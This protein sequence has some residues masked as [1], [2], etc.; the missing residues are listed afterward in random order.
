MKRSQPNPTV[1]R[2]RLMRLEPRMLYDGAAMAEAVAVDASHHGDDGP[3]HGHGHTHESSAGEKHH[4]HY[5]RSHGTDET[6]ARSDRESRHVADAR[7]S[8]DS[9]IQYFDFDVDVGSLTPELQEAARLAS[10]SILDFARQATDEQWF[11]LFNGGNEMPDAA[12]TARLNDLRTAL[13]DGSLSLHVETIDFAVMPDAIAAYTMNGPDGGLTIFINPVWTGMMEAPDLTHILVH[14]IGHAFDDILNNGGDTP[15][16]EGELFSDSILGWAEDADTLQRLQAKNDHR[17]IEWN[18]VSYEVDTATFSFVSTYEM[19]YGTVN[20]TLSLAV[21]ENSSIW[22]DTTDLGASFINDSDSGQHFNGNDVSAIGLNIG[23]ADYYGWISRPIKSE[24]VIRG[25]YFW[26]DA[27]FVDLASAQADGNKDG[28]N[29]PNDNRGF[30]LVIDQAWFAQQTTI[31]V[32]I[33]GKT[34]TVAN[35]KSSSDRVDTA[36]NA[37]VDK[38]PQPPAVTAEAQSAMAVEAGYEVPGSN[39]S[40]NV[41]DHAQSATGEDLTVTRISVANSSSSVQDVA[42]DGAGTTIA[43]KYGTLTIHVDGSYEYVVDNA[44]PKVDALNVGGTLDDVFTY[45]VSDGKG[46]IASAT[47]TIVIAGSNDAPQANPDY[48]SAKVSVTGSDVGYSATGN[49][50]LNDTDVDDSTFI[51]NGLTLTADVTVGLVNVD[52]GST[53]LSFPLGSSPNSVAGYNLYYQDPNAANTYYPLVYWDDASSKY[54]SITSAVVGSGSTSTLTLSGTPT[55]YLVGGSTFV[56][57]SVTGGDTVGFQNKPKDPLATL[58]NS[59]GTTALQVAAATASGSTTLYDFNGLEGAIAVGMTVKVDGVN[60]GAKVTAVNYNAITGELESVALD[61]PLTGITFDG[62]NQFSFEAPSSDGHTIQGAYGTLT[63]NGYGDYTYTPYA[64]SSLKS[65]QSAEEVFHYTI[66]DSGGLQSSS[67]LT[68]TVYGS[69]TD[70]LAGASV[71]A[72]ESGYNEPGWDAT[73]TVLSGSKWTEVVSFSRD[74]GTTQDAGQALQGAYG[75]LTIRAD[76]TFDYVVDNGNKTVNALQVGGTLTETFIYKVTDAG[77][78]TSY[79]RLTITIEGT[80]DA[81]VAENDAAAV[82]KGGVETATGNVLDNDTDVDT[83]DILRVSRA[84]PS[85]DALEDVT[86]SLTIEG[87][88]GTLTLHA[89]GSYAY[90]LVKNPGSGVVTNDVFTYE[91]KDSQGAIDTATLTVT[92][93]GA[94]EAP[95]NQM[96]GVPI[97][98]TGPTTVTTTADTPLDFT[99]DRLLSVD[100]ADGNLRDVTLEVDHGTLSFTEEPTGVTVTGSGQ[101]ITISGSQDA[102]NAALTLLRYTPDAGFYG[103]DFLTINSSDTDNARDSDG[104]AIVI[105]TE[106]AATVSEAALSTGS[107]PDSGDAT[108]A[109]M[110]TLGAG[111]TLVAQTGT[112]LDGANNEIGTWAVSSDGSFSVTLTKASSATASQFSYVVFD[113]YGNAINNIVNVTIVD[114]SPTAH[115]DTNSVVEGETATGNVLTNDVSGA[116]GPATVVG[117]RPAGEDTAT[118]VT[119]G[120]GSAIAGLYGTLTLNADGSY[121]YVA[122]S[123]TSG[124][125]DTFVYTIEDSD[126][127]RSTT[128]LTITVSSGANRPATFD[129]DSSASVTEDSGDYVRSGQIIVTDPDDP[130]ATIVAQ[131]NVEGS[132]GSFS[133]DA[134]GH[135]IY[136]ADNAKLKPLSIPGQATDRFTIQSNDGTTFDIVITLNGI[137][138]APTA[139]DDAIT[140]AYNTAKSGQLPDASDGDDGQSITYA[141][142]SDPTHGTLVIHADGSY[143]YTPDAGY[144]GT[145]SFTYTVSDGT[146]STAYTVTVTVADNIPATFNGDSSASVTEDSGDYTRT[147][148][149]IV[150]DPDD[151]AATIVAQTNVEGQYGSFNIDADGHWTYTADNAKLKPLS[152]DAQDTDTFTIQ[153][154]DGT[155]FDIVITLNGVN[156]APTAADDSITTA[157]NTAYTGQLPDASDVDEG[158]SITYAKGSDPAHGTVVIHADGSYTYTPEAG[159]SGAD[160]FTYSVSD[161]TDNTTYTVTITISDNVPATF[162]G[163]STANVTEDSGDYVRTGQ[164]VVTDPDDPAATIVAQTNVAGNYGSFS[165]DADGNWTYTADN[166]KLK[167]LSSPGQ[168]TD[169]FTIQSNDGTTFDIVITLNGVND[170]PT[171]A[172]DTI[173]TAYNTAISGQLPAASDVDEGDHVT[174]AKDADP[175]HGTVAVHADGSYTY[176]PEAGY[177]GADSFTYSVTDDQGASNTYTV[178]VTVA[179]NIP[180]SFAGDST[181]S[182]TEGSGDYTCS[183]QITVSDPDDAD[184]TIIAQTAEGQY[185]SFNID[186]DGHWTYTAD[187]AK[188]KPLSSPGQATDRFTIQ[189]ND[190]TT[191]EIVITL[192]G[193]NDAPTAADDSITTAYNTAILGQ[194][195]AASD[196]DDGQSITYAKD[197]DPAHGTVVVHADGSYTYTPE[198]GYSGADSF[199]YSVSDGTDNT[200]YTV[201]ITISDNIPATFDGDGT[202]SV[203]EDSGDYVR[204]GQIVVSDPDDPNATI[205]TQTNV[206]GQYGSFSIDADGN[207]TYTADNAKLKPLSTPGQATDTFTIQSSDGTTFEIVITLN[208]INDAPTAADDSIT[209]A[210]NTAISGQLP[211]ASDLDDGQSITYAKDSDPAYGTLVIHADGSY[212]YTPEDGYSGADSFTYSVS[213]GIDSN[214]YTVSVTVADNIPASFSGDSSAS[215]TEDSGDYVRSGKIDVTDPDDP[216][217]TIVAQTNVAGNYGSFNIDIDGH[218]T[219]A[220]DNAKLKPLSIPGQATDRFTIQSNDGTT[221]DI[222]IT[223]NGVNDAP[224]DAD[225]TIT[226]AYNTAKTSQLPA[227]S[228]VDEGDSVTYA[229][230]SDP[231]HGTVVIH[232]DGS[233]TYIPEDGYS[234]ADS[235]T[236]T[237]SDGTDSNTYTVMVTVSDNVPATFSGDSTASVT[238]DSN[239]YMRTGQ[240]T[241]SDPDDSNATIVAQTN[242][243]G[244]YG[245]FSIDADGYWTYTAD[246]AKLKPLSTPGQATDRFTIQSND[247][248]T[249]EIII[250]LNGVNDAPTAADDTITTAYNTAKSGQL[251]DATDVDG[252]QSITYAKGSDPAHGAVVVHAD[253]SYTYTPEDGYSGADS[254]TYSVSDGTD[255]NAYTVNMTVSAKLAPPPPSVPPAGTDARAPKIAPPPPSVPPAIG[256]T[257]PVPAADNSAMPPVT[258]SHSLHVLIAVQEAQDQTSGQGSPVDVL[259]F[260]SVGAELT[261]DPSLHVL[262]AVEAASRSHYNAWRNAQEL[263]ERKDIQNADDEN[264]NVGSPSPRVADFSLGLSK[265]GTDADALAAAPTPDT[266][267]G[268]AGDDVTAP[269]EYLSLDGQGEIPLTQAPDAPAAKIAENRR[270]IAAQLQRLSHRHRTTAQAGVLAQQLAEHPAPTASNQ[271][272]VSTV[273]R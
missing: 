265:P 213:D 156:D 101:S 87:A 155:T 68:I 34:V 59:N 255:S 132:Y 177:S 157:H 145:D 203:T 256:G 90:V 171:A 95:V 50:T 172:D 48:N 174:Y 88:Y 197:T 148:Q 47:L 17:T 271:P 109:G 54:V 42:S 106:S 152:Y 29:N 218:W 228:D 85:A 141:K 114:D 46:G 181:A 205:V 227:A 244:H 12:W 169:R 139:A 223:L 189:S 22:Y 135:W 24:G 220:A 151:S 267:A 10:Q 60:T 123:S 99:G 170:A 128:T 66:T 52:A 153:S 143:T 165:I 4:S 31:Q 6:H 158:Q 190:G 164:I 196:V 91:V 217:A 183:G 93:T 194:L 13:L 14:E 241:V 111:Q 37:E 252:G 211:D 119:S 198:D 19:V 272:V 208:G 243:E 120:A 191:F 2:L 160:S 224:T 96:G 21:K 129:G 209:T 74:D 138:D 182:V 195:P 233:Y 67:T 188:L 75:A 44:N 100:D 56:A 150:S 20:G 266:G 130:A 18:G 133:I 27:D 134:D 125:T 163:D 5:D 235:F 94:N 124:Q 103:T 49:V 178:S 149:I 206:E 7:D 232:A 215:V 187:N 35:V 79:A 270:D 212:T 81:P 98:D 80:N 268:D 113:D 38:T 253:G 1:S 55:G 28:D 202:A 260:S 186:A 204:T 71:T 58:T 102:L 121:S 69:G 115:P 23:G 225:D 162:D 117:V 110:L 64:D 43:G 254:F 41:L 72:K 108:F 39:A 176:M 51:V 226:T 53:T 16:E 83:G 65:G 250:T 137:N 168:A 77:G 104:I 82:A 238:E 200:T 242:V 221:F 251:P 263:F 57:H 15:G 257:P 201:T 240:I 76:G 146:D 180:A 166:V 89:D 173:T 219:Y 154:S 216:N 8:T 167:P 105:P 234:G 236:Y 239:D 229:K 70:D 248:T 230:G 86:G 84:G 192:N 246:N 259:G 144:S 207:W 210:H 32:E 116:D 11:A 3:S 45:T 179:D 126:G 26:T 107:D 249:F 245:S 214:T 269:G 273:R 63:M 61:I 161:G 112:L 262:P 78:N 40:G 140:T 199:T 97:S 237:V 264:D 25:F 9:P 258:T 136:T 30:I 131:T 247:G 159:Y 36:L 73:G 231:A 142:D 193:I 222:V 92:V 184:A 62:A 122:N 185:G 118:E 261:T 127:S 147:G 33:D 175:A